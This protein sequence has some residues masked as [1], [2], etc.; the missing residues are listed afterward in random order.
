MT[1]RLVRE[2]SID[3]ATL[4]VLFVDGA[5]ECFTCEDQIRERAGEPVA[6]WKVPGQTAIPQ[7]RYRVTLRESPRFAR[8]VPLVIAV[9]GF[10]DIEIHTGNTIGD[11]RGCIL[12]GKLRA[13]QRVGESRAAL[14]QLVAKVD[15]A[16]ARNE[17]IWLQVENPPAELAA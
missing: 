12:V 4:G 11:T 10:T 17:P 1:L 9:P 3:G 15:A 13:A 16:I 8:Q 6:T 14:E 5:F 2:P 7:G